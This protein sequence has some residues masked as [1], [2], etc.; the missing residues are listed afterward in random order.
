[1]ITALHYTS[2]RESEHFSSKIRENILKLKG[3]IP[4]ISVSQKPLSN[5]GENICVGVHYNCYFNMC[6]QIQIGL[7]H[8]S[9]PFTL[10]V[11]GDFLYSPEYFTFT[12]SEL[13]SYYYDNV[14]VLYDKSPP[15]RFHF[16]GRSTGAGIIPTKQWL[17]KVTAIFK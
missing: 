4:L 2:N 17:E 3:D 11:E 10:L 15:N 16:K 13:H 9:T 14:W 5:F 6:R 1:M 8:I 7:K 12:P